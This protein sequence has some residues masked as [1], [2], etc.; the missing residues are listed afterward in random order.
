[1]ASPRGTEDHF[2]DK[3]SVRCSTLF[4]SLRLDIV[5]EIICRNADHSGNN[6]TRNS[7]NTEIFSFFTVH[8]ETAT[9]KNKKIFFIACFVTRVLFSF[10]VLMLIAFTSRSS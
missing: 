6:F 9:C 7:R 4:G 2:T 8:R 3:E 10:S 1:M 5:F